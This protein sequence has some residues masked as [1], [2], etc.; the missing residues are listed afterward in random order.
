[1]QLSGKRKWGRPKWR[2]VDVVKDDMHEVRERRLRVCSKVT[3]NTRGDP[4][5]KSR[6]KKTEYKYSKHTLMI[7]L[8][9]HQRLLAS[10]RL[11]AF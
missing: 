4:D 10:L 6:L 5:G 7:I 1:M 9:L 8:L 3:E 2:Y 11:C